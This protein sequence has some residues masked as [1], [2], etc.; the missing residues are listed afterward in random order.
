MYSF[1][2]SGE[3][4]LIKGRQRVYVL[5][6]PSF[7]WWK[8]SILYPH[9][10]R[11]ALI[12]LKK[13]IGQRNRFRILDP[14]HWI[15]ILILF[16]HRFRLGRLLIVFCGFELSGFFVFVLILWITKLIQYMYKLIVSPLYFSQ[17]YIHVNNSRSVTFDYY[18]HYFYPKI[19]S[20]INVFQMAIGCITISEVNMLVLN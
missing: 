3:T 2:L 5:F 18:K 14:S 1:C 10:L 20:L 13:Y 4:A 11:P 7:I 6:P 8:K 16:A 9:C 12:H 15:Y 17:L 19:Q